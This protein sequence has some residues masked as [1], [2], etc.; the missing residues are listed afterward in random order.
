MKREQVLFIFCIIGFLA[1][2]LGAFGAHYLKPTLIE[3]NMTTTWNT[4]VSY[5]FYHTLAGLFFAKHLNSVK[6][7]VLFIVGIFFFSFSLYGLALFP[8]LKFLGPIT[9]IGGICFLT[10]W[11]VALAQ[12]VK[13]SRNQKPSES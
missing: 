7:P 5:Q 9:P 13:Q 10:G 12:L 1:V 4:A 6:V 2:M 3:R 11:I 8:S